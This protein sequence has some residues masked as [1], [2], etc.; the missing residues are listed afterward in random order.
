MASLHLSAAFDVMN[1]ELLIKRL[2]IVGLPVDLIKLASNWLMTRYLYVTIE[3]E[4]SF[5]HV[6]NVGTAQKSILGPILYAI[7]V[8]PLFDL[9]NLILFADDNYMV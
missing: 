8:S 3:G 2:R 9:T 6:T 5:V 1:V 4:N 7:F